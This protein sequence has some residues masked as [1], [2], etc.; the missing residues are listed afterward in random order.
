MK[1][2]DNANPKTLLGHAIVFLA[3][4]EE[5]ADLITRLPAVKEFFVIGDNVRK[6]PTPVQTLF[7]ER[8]ARPFR[9]R[10]SGTWNPL[11]K[12]MGEVDETRST[13]ENYTT[14][15][16]LMFISLLS[17]HEI[18]SALNRHRAV[19]QI[20]CREMYWLDTLRLGE[21]ADEA[22][23][24]ALRSMPS[25]V[26]PIAY[27][28]LTAQQRFD[29]TAFEFHRFTRPIHCVDSVENSYNG[30]P[31]Y[32]HFKLGESFGGVRT[33]IVTRAA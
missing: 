19:S 4:Y 25:V 12:A 31:F 2:Q 8:K 32:T 15:G 18:S 23:D 14:T 28:D 9:I 16:D 26:T 22:V 29:L 5:A 24:I 21:E 10:T 27:K 3:S 20:T 11:F 33:G 7:K 30:V 13:G 17:A 1:T 6:V